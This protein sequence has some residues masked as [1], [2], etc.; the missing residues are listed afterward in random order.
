VAA[1]VEEAVLV[2]EV[3]EVAPVVVE[4]ELPVAAVVVPEVVLKEVPRLS[5]NLTD[6]LVSSLPVERKIF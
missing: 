1:A 2:E 3:P 4:E 5:L 6:M